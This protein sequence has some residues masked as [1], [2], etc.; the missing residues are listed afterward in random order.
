MQVMGLCLQSQCERPVLTCMPGSTAHS[1]RHRGSCESCE[2]LSTL[3]PLCC[4]ASLLL[5]GLGV[6][7]ASEQWCSEW[8]WAPMRLR[9]SMG[10][11][12]TVLPTVEEACQMLDC[13]SPMG[14]QIFLPI[15][16]GR[17]CWWLPAWHPAATPGSRDVV[18]TATGLVTI[19]CSPAVQLHI[20]LLEIALWC[21]VQHSRDQL[22]TP[23]ASLERIGA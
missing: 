1:T 18:S 5:P 10:A 6:E 15:L 3:G 22:V 4:A 13:V 20:D 12:A 8:D 14:L 7:S 16:A 19:S 11:E 17:A 21:A 2:P 9:I 23:L